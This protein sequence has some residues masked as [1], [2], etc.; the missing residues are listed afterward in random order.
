M[1]DYFHAHIVIG[2]PIARRSVSGLA[3]A[4]REESLFTEEY[5]EVE[6]GGPEDFLNYLTPAGYLI[7]RDDEA[8]WGMFESLEPYLI[9]QKIPFDRHSDNYGEFHGENVR[10][11]PRLVEPVIRPSDNEGNE[12]VPRDEV[13]RLQK[14]NSIPYLRRRLRE[15]LGPEVPDLPPIDPSVFAFHKRAGRRR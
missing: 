4:A 7:F 3:R 1:S 14:V 15:I 8:R 2:G 13:E 5:R 9:K 12:Y 11:R 10:Y 6:I